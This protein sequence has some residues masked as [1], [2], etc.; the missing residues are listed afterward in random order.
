[1]PSCVSRQTKVKL[2]VAHIFVSVNFLEVFIFA[3]LLISFGKVSFVADDIK[4]TPRVK[5]VKIECQL[6]SD[7]AIKRIDF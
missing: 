6:S 7:S 2:H 4:K 3:F 1:M 5:A